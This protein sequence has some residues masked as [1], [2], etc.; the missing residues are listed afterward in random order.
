MFRETIKKHYKK[1][2]L[3]SVF[4]AAI[5]AVIFQL[6]KNQADI[7]TEIREELKP[8]GYTA[9]AILVKEIPIAEGFT[10]R[11]TVEPIKTVVLSAESDGKITYSGLENGRSVAKGATLLKVDGTIRSSSYQLSQDTYTKAQSDYLKLSELFKSG[12]ASGME[13]ENAK[14]AMQNAASQLAVSRKQVGQTVVRS[15]VNGIIVDRKVNQGEFVSTGAQIG[16]VA[17]L[18]SVRITVFVKQEQVGHLKKGD[19]VSVQSVSSP[20]VITKGRIYAIIPVA[21]AASTYPVEIRCANTKGFAFMGGMSVDVQ[22][23]QGTIAKVL[24]VPRTSITKIDTNN[25]VYVVHGN[26]TPILTQIITGKPVG[27]YLTVSNGLKA[28]D[29]VLTKG[30]LNVGAGK[31]LQQVHIIN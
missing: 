3:L 11:G 17:C 20:T 31:K 27:I 25:A 21:S 30:Q 13:V 5:L 29:T 10:Y 7:K 16:S 2:L 23:N 22:F 15:P 4:V 1:L 14:L 6:R 9:E 24:A 19:A 12:N 8:V 28:G 26:N 18:D